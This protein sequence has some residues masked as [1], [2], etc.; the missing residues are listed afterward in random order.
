M[1]VFLFQGSV[2]SSSQLQ[3]LVSVLNEFPDIWILSDEIYEHL[4]FD[5][6]KHISI[7]TFPGMYERTIVINGFSKGYAM[8]G[9][10]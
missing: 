5:N 10:R 8:T 7:A 4:L 2:Y 6:N 1:L 9:F 3:G